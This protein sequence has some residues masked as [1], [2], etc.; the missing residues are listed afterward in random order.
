MKIGILGAGSIGLHLA[1][2]LAMNGK[3]CVLICRTGQQAA[4]LNTEGLLYEDLEGGTTILKIKA[5]AM[6][7]LIPSLDF[8][9]IT[10]K[11][12]Q[13]RS[14]LKYLKSIDD[15]NLKVVSFQNGLGHEKLLAQHLEEGQP[16][17]FAS[18]T[19]GAYRISPSHVRHT[20]HGQTFVGFWDYSQPFEKY[21][22]EVCRLFAGTSLAVSA[23][24]EMKPRLWK[25]LIINSCINPLTA[26]LNVQNGLLLESP[27][28]LELMDR[29]FAEAAHVA[30]LEGVEIAEDFL[31][32][33][34]D[35]CRNTYQNKSSML[36]DIEQGQQTEIDYINGAIVQAAK[37]H[38]VNVPLQ[39]SVLTLVKAKQELEVQ[40]RAIK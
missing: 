11:Q 40:Q 12:P 33:I 2:Q 32:E 24:M 20:G 9:F 16:L 34:V 3:E 22:D 8:L 6:D 36:Q 10:V 14:A 4:K 5:V 30:R 26:I 1:G 23:E 21:I 29:L 27:A 15:P 28:T 13:L 31:K 7:G 17:F 18:T 38:A 25:K 39:Q 19:E 35:V 37:R